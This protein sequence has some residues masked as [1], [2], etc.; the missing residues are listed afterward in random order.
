MATRKLTIALLANLKKNAP[1]LPGEP[2]DAHDDLDSEKTLAALKHAL[3]SGGHKVEVFEGNLDVVPKLRKLKPDIA[4]N[5]CEMHWGDSREAQIPAILEMLRIPYTG[6]KLLTMALTQDKPMTKRVLTFHGLPTPEFQEFVRGDEPLDPKLKFPLFVKPS[7]EGTGIGVSGKSVVENEQALREQVNWVIQ[8]YREPAL[9]ER[10]IEGREITLGLIGNPGPEHSWVRHM[11][12]GKLYDGTFEEAI[13]G[14]PF[15]FFPPLEVDF[16]KYEPSER[17]V[18]TNRIKV[19]LAEEFYVL[20]PAPLEPKKL[21]E[22]QRLAAATFQVTSSADVA[23][24]DFRLDRHN[25][26]KPYILEINPLPGLCPGISDL[27]IE[28]EAEGIDH[29]RLVNGILQLAMR[30]QGVRVPAP[31]PVKERAPRRA[32]RVVTKPAL[33]P[34]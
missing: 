33:Q 12:N 19:E 24:V 13:N 11:K 18:Y 3:E 21:K 32:P 16:S 25:N 10:F 4:F 23:R 30:R 6:S 31:E 27:C 14:G 29:T 5:I 15:H 22:L 34:A 2:P 7:R 28:A 26:D 20:C 8:T 1:H 17:G 9:V